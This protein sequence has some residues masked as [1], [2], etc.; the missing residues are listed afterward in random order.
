M[1]CCGIAACAV[2]LSAL[3]VGKG[4]GRHDPTNKDPLGLLSEDDSEGT[5]ETDAW[6][7][8]CSAHSISSPGGRHQCADACR[9]YDCCAADADEE[10]SNCADQKEDDC[11]R[12][13]KLCPTVLDMPADPTSATK[14]QRTSNW[15]QQ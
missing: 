4:R 1:G 14:P 6:E 13:W 15:E 7:R 5:S 9:I 2:L 8:A 3:L 11:E 12:F 10:E